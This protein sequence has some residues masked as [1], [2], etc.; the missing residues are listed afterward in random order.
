MGELGRFTVYLAPGEQRDLSVQLVAGDWGVYQ[1]TVDGLSGYVQVTI[2]KGEGFVGGYVKT[3][4]GTALGGVTVTVGSVTSITNIEGHYLMAVPAGAYQA[5]FSC[6]GYNQATIS[7]NVLSGKSTAVP[8]VY[9]TPIQTGASKIQSVLLSQPYSGHPYY[10]WL[11]A[12]QLQ[13]G[14][15][16]VYP[17]GSVQMGGEEGAPSAVG[18]TCIIKVTVRKQSNYWKLQVNGAD[19]S[20]TMSSD[21]FAWSMTFARAGTYQVNLKIL[22]SSNKTDWTL[23]DEA[24]V[25][26]CSII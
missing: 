21:T 10:S 6:P 12:N 23:T 3:Q 22:S 14:W 18:V 24:D 11:V 8:T 7:V 25:T 5:S 13:W 20:P 26:L 17:T 16:S 2:A 4:S 15:A 1:V 9:L 19:K